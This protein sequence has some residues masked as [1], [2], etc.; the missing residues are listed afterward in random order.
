MEDITFFAAFEVLSL[1]FQSA[2]KLD[3]GTSMFTMQS[4]ELYVEVISSIHQR[5]IC[6]LF[7]DFDKTYTSDATEVTIV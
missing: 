2:P 3:L 4:I 1:Q 7:S 5:L 6:T